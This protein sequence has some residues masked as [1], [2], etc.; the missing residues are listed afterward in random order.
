[1]KEF[2][3]RAAHDCLPLRD[4]L[5]T[6]GVDVPL[7]CSMCTGEV[8][9]SWHV[10]LTC[11]CAK[12]CWA[13]ANLQHMVDSFVP[14]A[15]SFAEWVSRMLNG[16]SDEEAGKVVAIL[17]G[18]WRNRNDLV[19]RGA[20]R[21]AQ[22]I[23]FSAIHFLCDWL[24]YREQSFL[25]DSSNSGIDH[26]AKTLWYPGLFQIREGEAI[27]ILEAL[28]WVY[29]LGFQNVLF[30]SDSKVVVD[31]INSKGEDMSEFGTIIGHCRNLLQRER[32]FSL[33]FIK[34]LANGCAH[35]FARHSHLYASPHI[36]SSFPSF[37]DASLLNFCTVCAL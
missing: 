26:L 3:W 32:G 13:E 11:N 28:S 22:I 30:E 15:D 17:W 12:E 33:H 2:L 6:R 23:V 31:A 9:S 24:Q 1:M 25:L 36:W 5:F 4:R 14:N 27:G 37:L 10:F 18:I 34:R 19:W 29:D 21:L 7:S 35:S 16:C 8:E 20:A